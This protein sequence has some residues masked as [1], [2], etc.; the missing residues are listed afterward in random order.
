[1]RYDFGLGL[2]VLGIEARVHFARSPFRLMFDAPD[3]SVLLGDTDIIGFVFDREVN[4]AGKLR[5][6]K[7]SG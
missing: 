6:S 3:M 7:R 5:L 2:D 1:L 4:G